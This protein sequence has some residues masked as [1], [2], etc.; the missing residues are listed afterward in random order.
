MAK[1]ISDKEILIDLQK[2]FRK[3]GR[4]FT[5]G[6]YSRHGSHHRD[7]LP[8][9]FGSFSEAIKKAGL[10]EKFEKAVENRREEILSM[11]EP[12]KPIIIK[13]SWAKKVLKK[14]QKR[15]KEVVIFIMPDKHFPFHDE[16]YIE[17]M[18]AD[19]AITQPDYVID[20][21]D[22]QDFFCFSKFSRTAN[23]TT[24]HDEYMR[25]RLLVETLWK[26]IKKISP[27][28]KCYQL[29]GNHEE[30]LRSRL[31]GQ[32]PELEGFVDFN[33]I[34]DVDGVIRTNSTRESI[35]IEGITFVHGLFNPIGAHMRHFHTSVVYA[36]THSASIVWFG[37]GLFEFNCGCGINEKS[38]P[39]GYTRSTTTK[40]QKGWGKIKIRSG[41]YYPEFIPF[42]GDK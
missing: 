16:K 3:L 13:P 29:L 42:S 36:H 1:K 27:K 5:T 41:K 12:K 24:P 25:G 6:D 7:I 11:K 31:L 21:G 40:W 17:A 38:I 2:V 32:S 8:A 19:I 23:L 14:G 26:T 15:E 10:A 28:S 4:P 34:F 22:M 30:R 9:R 35:V 39:F 20:M 33:K 18:V 37:N